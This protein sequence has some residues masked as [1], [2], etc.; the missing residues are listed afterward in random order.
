MNAQPRRLKVMGVPAVGG[1]LGRQA[2]P[3]PLRIELELEGLRH[4]V[5]K[6]AEIAA[7]HRV[8][9]ADRLVAVDDE[10]R[11]EGGVGGGGR[12]VL[13]LVRPGPAM[14]KASRI[15]GRYRPGIP[16]R[17]MIRTF[18]ALPRPVSSGV[19]ERSSRRSEGGRS[20]TVSSAVFGR[21]RGRGGVADEPVQGIEAGGNAPVVELPAEIALGDEEQDNGHR[22]QQQDGPARAADPDQAGDD[23]PDDQQLP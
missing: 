10:V 7:Q 8:Q 3:G 2:F 19:P 5:G 21:N 12:Q 6:L 16:S 22:A 14:P 23:G 9:T 18:L 1:H 4:V 11:D 15:S 17:A 13:H 20:A